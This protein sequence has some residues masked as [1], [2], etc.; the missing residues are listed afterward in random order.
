[1]QLLGRNRNILPNILPVDDKTG[2]Y[3]IFFYIILF[4]FFI[5]IIHFYFYFF[6]FLHA[7]VT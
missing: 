1:M 6:S 3:Q 5:F 7:C 2:E 4:I